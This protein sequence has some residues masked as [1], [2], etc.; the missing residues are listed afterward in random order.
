[1][2][3][4]FPF[5]LLLDIPSLLVGEKVHILATNVLYTM[6]LYTLGRAGSPEQ[7]IHCP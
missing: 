4:L 5:A 1:M 7:E 6:V 2:V 3:K